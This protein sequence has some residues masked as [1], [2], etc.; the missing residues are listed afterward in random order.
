MIQ[1]CQF[2]RQTDEMKRWME[3]V[4]EQMNDGMEDQEKMKVG[5]LVNIMC[6]KGAEEFM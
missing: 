4:E 1:W 5:Q 6:H 3:G 2:K